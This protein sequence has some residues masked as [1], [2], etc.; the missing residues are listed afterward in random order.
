MMKNIVL[1][2][3]REYFMK[4]NSKV[5]KKEIYNEESIEELQNIFDIIDKQ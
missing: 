1:K 2:L 5:D 4:K 3:E